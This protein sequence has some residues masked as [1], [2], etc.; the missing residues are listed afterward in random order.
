MLS[1]QSVDCGDTAPW[2][3]FPVHDAK[4]HTRLAVEF[5]FFSR[6]MPDRTE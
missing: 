5:R 1:A 4:Y 3:I 2:S 6:S